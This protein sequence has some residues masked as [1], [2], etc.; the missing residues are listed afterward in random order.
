MTQEVGDPTAL[1]AT[2]GLALVALGASAGLLAGLLGVGGGLVLVPGLVLALGLRQHSA[3]ATSL[4]VIGPI[5]VVGGWRL[6]IAGTVDAGLALAIV[7]GSVPAAYFGARVMQRAPAL[8]LR[9]V[10]ALVMIGTAILIVAR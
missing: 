7:A 8:V 4:A 3:H 10:F 5:A 2:S 6:A 9:R 1:R